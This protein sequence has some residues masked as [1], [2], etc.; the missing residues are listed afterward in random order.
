MTDL[1]SLLRPRMLPITE[2]TLDLGFDGASEGARDGERECAR[3]LLL[4]RCLELWWDLERDLL[5]RWEATLPSS[6]LRRWNSSGTKVEM[7][8]LGAALWALDTVLLAL[9]E[10]ASSGLVMERWMERVDGATE[11]A[12][13]YSMALSS[14]ALDGAVEGATEAAGTYSMA[15]GSEALEDALDGALEGATEAAGTYSD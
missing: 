3:D 5:E 9:E 13:A 8:E 7:K 4:E 10:V 6:V 11:G 15:L 14:A 1:L 2:P 12:G